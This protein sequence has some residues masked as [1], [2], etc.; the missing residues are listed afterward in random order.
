MILEGSRQASGGPWTGGE[1]WGRGTS[2]MR[3]LGGGW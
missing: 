3:R 2:R 1:G